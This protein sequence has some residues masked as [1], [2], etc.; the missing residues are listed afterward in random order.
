MNHQQNFIIRNVKENLLG[1]KKMTL[2]GNMDLLKW[3]KNIKNGNLQAF[4][5]RKQ[6]KMSKQIDI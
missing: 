2:D 6:L 1:R 5:P 4:I 3:I